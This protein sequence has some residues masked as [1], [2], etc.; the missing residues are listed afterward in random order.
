MMQNHLEISSK[1]EF[2]IRDVSNWSKCLYGKL[3]E[4]LRLPQ[5]LSRKAHVGPH[6]PIWAHKGPYGPQLGTAPVFLFLCV[7]V[8]F[9]FISVGALILNSG[10]LL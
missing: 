9:W 7:H 4:S 1:S 3:T 2:W 8:L 5:D 6:G 10:V